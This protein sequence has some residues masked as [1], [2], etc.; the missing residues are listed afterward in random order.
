M[1]FIELVI[2]IHY[3]V[4]MKKI[5]CL[6]CVVI[7]LLI[8]ATAHSVTQKNISDLSDCAYVYRDNN[9]TGAYV[10]GY[11][12][13]KLC[14]AKVLPSLEVYSTSVNGK[15]R[16]ITQNNSICYA[17]Y[18]CGVYNYNLIALDTNNG[19]ISTYSFNAM[20]TIDNSYLA[21][22]GNSVYFVLTDSAYSYVAC[23]DFSGALQNKYKLNG[24]VR[25]LFVNDNKVYA[26]IDN[27][28]IF[29]LNNGNSKF[30]VNIN[31]SFKYD[32]CCCGKVA[33]ET[34]RVV[35]LVDGSTKIYCKSGFQVLSQ[36][37]N[38][39]VYANGNSLLLN[40]GD[41][42]I[43]VSYEIDYV[44]MF[45]E[46]VAVISNNNLFTYSLKDFKGKSSSFTDTQTNL[47]NP[48]PIN[49]YGI[50]YDVDSGTTVTNFKKHYNT[51]IKIF[52]TNNLEIT[53]GKIK[54]NYSASINNETYLIS[55]K[56]D[57]TGEGNVKSNDVKSLMSY[58]NGKITL[59]NV[60]QQSADFNNDGLVDNK[61]LVLIS[62]K[63]KQ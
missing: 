56:G 33:D 63:S 49:Q 34:G 4:R 23:Y 40:N 7:L 60:Y 58:L 44:L 20:K 54:T 24:N 27:G 38:N 9:S 3:G 32:N 55:V 50:I 14:C 17:L 5:F 29:Y 53:S 2:I 51:P 26:Q 46:S 19:N 39:S 8:S 41:K 61:D 11:N 1:C 42:C 13:N 30:C 57:V 18:E 15:I 10:Y 47:L 36:Y 22:S 48:Y 28:D 59:N 52:D 43:D 16:S 12:I 6:F 37:S 62:R 45:K 21:V 35:S 31:P 25:K